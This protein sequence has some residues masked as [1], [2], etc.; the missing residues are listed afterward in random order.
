M[1]RLYGVPLGYDFL[2]FLD[3]YI[4]HTTLDHP[5]MI[6]KGVIQDLGENLGVLSRNILLSDVEEIYSVTDTDPLIYFDILGRYLM[7]YKLSTSKIIQ[8][9]LILFVIGIGIIL[10]I[11][12]HIWHRQRTL[13]CSG[14]YCIYFHFKYPFILRIIT[15]IIY[16]ISHII[17][18]MI[19]LLFSL[20]FAVTMSKVRPV[21]WHGNPTLAIFLFS[22]PCLIGSTIIGYLFD[23]FHRFILG[24]SPK[25][26][27]EFNPKYLN[28]LNFDFE[29]N[30]SVL[31]VYV[32]LMI[33]AIRFNQ[34]FYII[35][36]WS[37]FICPIY[38]L[39]MI[40]QFIVHWKEKHLNFFEEGYHWLY[41]PLII[42]LLPLAH[43]IE[44]ISRIIRILIPLFVRIFSY[45]GWAFRLHLIMS[46]IIAIPTIF[47][48]LIFLPILQRT[49]QF[50]RT[51]IVLLIIFVIVISVALI[52]QPFTK[53]YPNAFYAEHMSK[54]IFT[55]EKLTNVPFNVPLISQTSSIRV[56][57]YDGVT[58]L[59]VLDR[60]SSKSGHILHN[61]HCITSTNCTFDDIFNRKLAV[62]YI[63]IESM[64]NSQNYTVIIRHVL[65][66]NI[67]ISSLPDILLIV[68]NELNIPRKETKVDVILNS[69]LFT[70][71]IDIKFD[72]VK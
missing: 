50:G 45:S 54:S 51:L 40:I 6:R 1:F 11:L 72:D 38:L 58:L 12:D 61:K 41:L 39:L 15:I 5:S 14:T 47:F 10:I 9:I 62:E 70:F 2:F 30:F 53:N 7:V 52:R 69:R 42:S 68:R 32:L 3:G 29:Q 22:F 16:S 37:I 63:K 64:K 4:Y 35:L 71:E 31:L 18:V 55:V 8:R 48:V 26:S 25:N 67:R 59:P 28:Q 46:C 23:R 17:S 34:L 49:K 21:S 24:K 60:F 44:I 56:T 33:L 36:V 27:S 19:G 65:S 66:Y 57:T 43:T 20:L 13:K